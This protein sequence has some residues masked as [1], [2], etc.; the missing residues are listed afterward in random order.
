MDTKQRTTLVILAAGMGSRYGGIKQLDSFGENGETIIEYA[1]YDAERAGFT[2][3]LFIIR[4]EIQED[5]QKLLLDRIKTKLRISLAFQETSFLPQGWKPTE[6]ALARTKPWGTA[7]ALW[8]A[9]EALHT[10]FAVIN[11]DDFYGRRSFELMQGFLVSCNPSANTY[12]MVAFEL[13][14]TLSPHGPVSRGIC[15]VDEG[16]FLRDI[17]EHK[18]IS[19]EPKPGEADAIVSC[20]MMAPRATIPPIPQSP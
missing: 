2:D 3:A 19:W 8:C 15:D 14:K 11:A 16:G 20:T 17:A 4:Q 10:P 9:R 12:A 5:F 18:K 7:H 6:V 1:L 13:G